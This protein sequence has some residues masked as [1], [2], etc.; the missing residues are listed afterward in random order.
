MGD[1]WF[2]NNNK[3]VVFGIT[4]IVGLFLGWLITQIWPV[5]NNGNGKWSTYTKDSVGKISFTVTG[6]TS[7][8]VTSE[9]FGPHSK[10]VWVQQAG[11][12]IHIPYF[13]ATAPN[14][15]HKCGAEPYVFWVLPAG[16]YEVY[17]SSDF[18]QLCNSPLR[19]TPYTLFPDVFSSIM[20]VVLP[21]S[22][23]GPRQVK[24]DSYRLQTGHDGDETHITIVMQS[25]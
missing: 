5:S 22:G 3:W 13:G 18:G 23:L 4:F 24:T 7:A 20:T 19:T 17:A 1:P 9:L 2:N 25:N 8:I 11:S 21:G 12:T 14:T 10:S 15:D 6:D 16:S